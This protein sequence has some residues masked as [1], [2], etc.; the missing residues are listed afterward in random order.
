VANPSGQE[1]ERAGRW[2]ARFDTS[3]HEITRAC[4]Y[5]DDGTL[6][7]HAQPVISR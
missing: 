3:G 7:N 2:P 4:G 6:G 5:D 1:A